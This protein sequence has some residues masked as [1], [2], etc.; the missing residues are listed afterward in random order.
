M[1]GQPR[2]G[3]GM[4]MIKALS[5]RLTG[6]SLR[7]NAQPEAVGGTFGP[8]LMRQGAL[9]QPEDGSGRTLAGMRLLILEDDYLIGKDLAHGPQLEGMEILGPY[10]SVGQAQAVL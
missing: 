8:A 1:R 9:A 2:N 7:S 6:I 3:K 4:K 5:T 10:F